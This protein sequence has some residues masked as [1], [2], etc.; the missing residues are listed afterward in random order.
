MKSDADAFTHIL[1]S[2]YDA[3]LDDTQWPAALPALVRHPHNF[4]LGAT[5]LPFGR[6][7]SDRM[8]YQHSFFR[9]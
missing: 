6:D 5:F 8:G 3:M 1:A 7:R 4:W 2:L 9:C